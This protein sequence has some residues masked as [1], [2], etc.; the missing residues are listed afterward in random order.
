MAMKR[1]NNLKLL[2]IQR[3]VFKVYTPTVKNPLCPE[4]DYVQPSAFCLRKNIMFKYI[5]IML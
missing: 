2:L 5:N 1:K 3:L 4:V